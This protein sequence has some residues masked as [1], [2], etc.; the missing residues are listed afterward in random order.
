MALSNWL[1]FKAV[2]RLPVAQYQTINQ[3][4]VIVVVVLGWTVLGEGLSKFQLIG[5]LLLLVAALLAIRAPMINIEKQHR[6]IHIQSVA[7]TLA[8]AAILGIALVIEKAALGYMDIGAYLIFGYSAQT[9]AML[10]LATKDV[11]RGTLRTFGRSELKWSAG[12]GW[13]NA[14]TGV[15]YVTAIV[16]SDNISLVTAIASI[17]LPLLAFAAYVVLKEREN[18]K[19]LWLGLMIGFLGLLVSSMG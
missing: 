11:R 1:N 7:L 10:V 3:F 12:M 17:T 19:L 9:L 18:Q 5:A 2:K 4:Y 15:F 8:A 13:A 14:I 6:K 16:R